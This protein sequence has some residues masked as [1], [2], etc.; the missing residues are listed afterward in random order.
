MCEAHS[1]LDDLARTLYDTMEHLDPGP[2]DRIDWEAL[3]V[4][5]KEFYRTCIRS[6][7]QHPAFNGAHSTR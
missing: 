3:S 5:E 1:D 6:L 2:S 7:L 4:R